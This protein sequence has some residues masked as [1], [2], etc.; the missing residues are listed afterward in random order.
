MCHLNILLKSE[1]CEI[2]KEDLL[3]FLTSVTTASYLRNKD[4]DGVY[5]QDRV[6][7]SDE[8]LN[9]AK[10]IDEVYKSNVVL[11]H[12]RIST[13]GKT[14]KF[15]Q[16]F[17]NEQFALMHNGIISGLAKGEASDTYVFFGK[18]NKYFRLSNKETRPK[19][20]AHAIKKV[21]KEV[22]S[23]TYS[24]AIYDKVM[25][26]VYYFKNYTPN[27]T[28]WRGDNF[29]YMSTEEDNG[30]FLNLIKEGFEEAL[31]KITPKEDKLYRFKFTENK[32]EI[33][34]MGKLPEKK[35]W[36]CQTPRTIASDF[37]PRGVVYRG[38]MDDDLYDFSKAQTDAYNLETQ[39]SNGISSGVLVGA[40]GSEMRKIIE[41]SKGLLEKA[42]E[43]DKG[44]DTNKA[45]NL[46]MK[47]MELLIE[48]D[49]N[50][51]RK[52]L[53]AY[54]PDLGLVETS[55][56]QCCFCGDQTTLFSTYVGEHICE[57][58]IEERAYEEGVYQ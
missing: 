30:K 23:G 27:M 37:V 58:C 17:E 24:I 55:K 52:E 43:A 8:K 53:M 29:I 54:R 5:F 21:L 14:S 2:S 42:I 36:S 1:K 9:F 20:V 47:A 15:N 28:L 38:T 16:P 26:E 25:N 4:A 39:S 32:I 6:I 51:L 41:D 45:T 48:Q 40:D 13:S 46:R 11:S 56:S 10:F 49:K 35:S 57:F 18:F 31:T 50:E 34:S 12:Q 33:E 19:R 3:V 22:D 44:N 7:K